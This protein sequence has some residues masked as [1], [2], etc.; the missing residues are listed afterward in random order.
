MRR[1]RQCGSKVY[2][3]RGKAINF[4]LLAPQRFELWS[5]GRCYQQLLFRFRG[6]GT[7]FSFLVGGIGT[8]GSDSQ[9]QLSLA[10]R[11]RG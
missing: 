10:S 7:E 4:R 1:T 3:K 11:R 2:K 9:S 5:T 6:R 8:E